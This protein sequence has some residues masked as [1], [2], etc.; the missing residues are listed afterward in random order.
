MLTV[1]GGLAEFER[2][3]IKAR[4]SDGRER[5]NLPPLIKTKFEGDT[6]LP[7]VVLV[8]LKFLQSICWYRFMHKRLPSVFLW[9]K[10]RRVR[11]L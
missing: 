1:L 11:H 7:G 8:C 2:E 9:P 6:V 10:V 5:A 4:T 3:L